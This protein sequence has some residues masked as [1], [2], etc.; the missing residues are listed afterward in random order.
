MEI[1]TIDTKNQIRQ[2][3]NGQSLQ[4][5]LERMQVIRQY[6]YELGML[7]GREYHTAIDKEKR[8][9]SVTRIA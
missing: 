3:E 7:M 2:M 8:I 9:I 4:Y 6:A 1:Q 5:P